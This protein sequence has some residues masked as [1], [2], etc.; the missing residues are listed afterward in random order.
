MYPF[1]ING[2]DFSNLVNKYGVVERL[3]PV[4][5]GSIQDLDGITHSKVIRWRRNVTFPI[6]PL[7][8]AQAAELHAELT[9]DPLVVTYFSPNSN[10]SVS[11]RMQ[12]P[13]LEHELG[14][15]N[16][17]KRHWLGGTLNLAEV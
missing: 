2:K 14:L 9:A 8:D 3:E 16:G 13:T 17:N 7:T 11:C 6:N 1:V 10:E 4:L 15:V 12:P 5:G